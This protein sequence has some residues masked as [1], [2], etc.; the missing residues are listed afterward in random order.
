[1]TKM[2]RYGRLRKHHRAQQPD[3]WSRDVDNLLPYISRTR[4]C[5]LKRCCAA[6]WLSASS[7]V[8]LPTPARDR[9]VHIQ[10]PIETTTWHSTL[11]IFTSVAR[12][13][14]ETIGRR[15]C[16]LCPV[17][18]AHSFD[19]RHSLALSGIEHVRRQ[20][21]WTKSSNRILPNLP[22]I[23]VLQWSQPTTM[24]ISCALEQRYWRPYE[25]EG[26]LR[27]PGQS[28]SRS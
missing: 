4:P 5:F 6:G 16:N 7:T 23:L 25:T 13:V 15:W 27:A 28:C 12:A 21:L 18:L 22:D 20:R 2:Y 24:K 1:M 26:A 8:D 14:W 9:R 19:F 11:L 17:D 3:G 10:L